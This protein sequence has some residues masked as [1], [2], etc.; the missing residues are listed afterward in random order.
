VKHTGEIRVD[1][2]LPHVG[3][4]INREGPDAGIGDHDPDRPE[5]VHARHE[6]FPKGLLIPYVGLPPEEAAADCFDRGGCLLQVV[7]RGE[8]VGN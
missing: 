8:R 3:R 4:L 2:V 1:D 6:G 5:F 7:G